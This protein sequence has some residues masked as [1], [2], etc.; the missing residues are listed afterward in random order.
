MMVGIIKR[1]AQFEEESSPYMKGILMSSNNTFLHH[2]QSIQF[3]ADANQ[4]V[5]RWRGELS[6]GEIMNRSDIRINCGGEATRSIFLSGT[7]ARRM[8]EMIKE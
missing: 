4:A 8:L 2:N 1:K 5:W 3:C 6:E 7:A